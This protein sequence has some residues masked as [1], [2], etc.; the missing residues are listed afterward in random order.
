MRRRTF[1]SAS[2]GLGLLAGMQAYRHRPQFAA[3]EGMS[4]S[5]VPGAP[6]PLYTGAA[7]AFG[8]TISVQVMH[9]NQ[10][11]AE[12]AIGNALHEAKKIDALMSLHRADSQLVTLNRQGTLHRPDPHLLAVMRETQRLAE[13]TGGA[14]DPTVQPLWRL[15]ADAASA[16]RIAAPDELRQ[17]IRLVDWRKVSVNADRIAFSVPGMAITLN[18]IAQGYASDLA[19]AAVREGGIEHA[20]L[21]IGEFGAVGKNPLSNPW[22]LGVRH[23]REAEAMAAVLTVNGR[24]MATSGDYETSFSRDFSAHHIIDPGTGNSPPALA[25]VTVLA[26]TCMLADGLSTAMF[27]M[28]PDKALALA[29][30]YQGVD[31]LLIGKDGRTWKTLGLPLVA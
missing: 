28:G 4:R 25:S 24:S 31:A 15:H 20:L 23:P 10:K 1:L 13:Q 2:L 11:Q 19:L 27:V 30:R 5:D 21:D 16:G 17:A 22:T 29:A 14:F 3:A 26:P 12:L 18:G 8:T 9:R 7:I 6:T